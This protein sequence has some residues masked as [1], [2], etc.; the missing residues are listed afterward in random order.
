MVK[1]QPGP[2]HI[3]YPH[4]LIFAVS[5]K[6]LKSVPFYPKCPLF[7]VH[8]RRWMMMHN[9]QQFSL[10]RE[11]Y[12]YTEMFEK[13]HGVKSLTLERFDHRF[14]A[15]SAVTL[16]TLMLLALL[17]PR[18]AFGDSPIREMSNTVE[19]LCPVLAGVSDSLTASERD[20]FLRC[21]EVKIKVNDGQA[22]EDL[23]DAQLNAL[24]NMTGDESTTQ[25]TVNVR[26]VGPQHAAIAARLATLRGG[27]GGGLALNLNQPPHEM[28]LLAG[29]VSALSST[30]Q[31][32]SVLS[33]FGRI[34]SFITGSI[35]TGEKDASE[36]IPGFD[37]S[38]T[39]ITAGMDYRFSER[40]ISGL[41]LG[42][43]SANADITFDSGELDAV[44]WAVS[45]YGTYY[46]DRLYLNGMATAGWK[47]YDLKRHV[48]Y[49]VTRNPNDPNVGTSPEVAVDQTFTGE[50]DASEYSASLGAGYEFDFGGLTLGPYANINYL[51]TTIDGFNEKLDT[52]NT[53]EGFGLALSYDSRDIESV[54][55]NVGGQAGFAWATSFGIL[56]PYTRVDW[57]HQ[58]NTDV[59]DIQA[60]FV[61]GG[62]FAEAVA[63]NRILI[64]TEDN[65]PD[66]FN[67]GAGL[68]ATLP[69]GISAFFDYATI[70]GLKDITFHQFTGGLRL[71]I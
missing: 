14:A 52:P 8:T 50:S 53:N 47:D 66:F 37:Y 54:T 36:T 41:A 21:G 15:F 16:L 38:G 30:G 61:N 71:E 49:T 60:K 6:S 44:G 5:L 9:K 62:T 10:V 68:A 19:S 39:A 56:S 2:S 34:G 17:L 35:A 31:D 26:L 3:P 29:P 12:P 65:D 4:A 64:P 51:T 42:Y 55:T 22:F 24:S 63:N 18:T 45:L 27:G 40:F 69:Y 13:P 1:G 33:D 28:I 20:V 48:N 32:S 57:T 46:L 43:A 7:D 58:Y 59:D 25:E 23:T 67:F 11:L 70:W